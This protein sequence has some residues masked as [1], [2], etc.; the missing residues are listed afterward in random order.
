MDR[1][2]DAENTIAI[3][4]K[5]TEGKVLVLGGLFIVLPAQPAEEEIFGH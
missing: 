4:P 3:C 5:G 2:T 1:S